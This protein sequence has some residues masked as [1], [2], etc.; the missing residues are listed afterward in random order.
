MHTKITSYNIFLLVITLGL[1]LIPVS[2]SLAQSNL[3]PQPGST[4][5]EA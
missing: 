2:S 5:A 4:R 1:L 3:A